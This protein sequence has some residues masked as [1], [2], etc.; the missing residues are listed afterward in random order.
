MLRT[1]SLKILVL[2]VKSIYKAIKEQNN[3]DNQVSEDLS[4][5]SDSKRGSS[6]TPSHTSRELQSFGEVS[7]SDISTEQ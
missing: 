2:T 6:R 1:L 3:K 4:D 5:S 7:S